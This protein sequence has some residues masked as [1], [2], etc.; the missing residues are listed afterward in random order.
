M[1]YSGISLRCV[2]VFLLA[3]TCAGKLRNIMSALFCAN[4]WLLRCVH[5]E[6]KSYS[7]VWQYAT[8]L[9][10]SCRI[11]F[12]STIV[13]A[14][15]CPSLTIVRFYFGN[16]GQVQ[17]KEIFMNSTWLER[18]CFFPPKSGLVLLLWS[19]GAQ[20]FYLIASAIKRYKSSSD[21]SLFEIQASKLRLWKKLGAL[22]AICLTPH[23]WCTNS[24]AGGILWI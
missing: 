15:I 22:S 24:A 8:R 3:S 12:A 2:S 10:S 19:L 14:G 21:F 18:D 13:P 20:P 5:G 11:T 6:L 9:A 17:L 1:R 7:W 4:C 16:T 23:S